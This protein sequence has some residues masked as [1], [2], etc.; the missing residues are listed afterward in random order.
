MFVFPMK[1][2]PKIMIISNLTAAKLLE[3]DVGNDSYLLEARTIIL[4]QEDF[5]KL[6][7]PFR[8]YLP[9]KP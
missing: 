3:D 6:K 2:V 5:P 9:S 7:G 8:Y 1:S 4:I